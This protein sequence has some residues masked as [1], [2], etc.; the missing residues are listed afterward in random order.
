V[1]KGNK[2]GGANFIISKNNEKI[3]IG[4]ARGKIQLKM[5]DS[6]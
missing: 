6:V 5:G 4:S 1:E 2:K 3:V